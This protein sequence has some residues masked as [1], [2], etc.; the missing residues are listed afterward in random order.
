MIRALVI[1]LGL[2]AG[3]AV[4]QDLGGVARVD[5][6]SSHIRDDGRGIEIQLHLSQSVPFRVITLD[7]PRRLVLDFREIDWSGLTPDQI[8]QEG[9]VSGLRF[10]RYAATWSRM[11]ADLDGPYAVEQ[12]GMMV[13][14]ATGRSILRL[15]LRPSTPEAFSARAGVP[16]GDWTPRA[17][18]VPPPPRPGD[19]RLRVVLDPGHGGIDPGAQRDGLREADLMLTIAR[20]VKDTLLRTGD[21]EVAMT[22]EEDVFVPLETR[23][24]IA[25]AAKAHVFVSLHADAL[26]EGN[27]RGATVYT[28]SDTASDKAAQAMAERHSRDDLLAG[29]DLTLQDDQ[30]A[31]VLMDLARA[32]TAPRATR[33][34][35]T[36]VQTLK[37]GGLRVNKKP[38]R[39]AAISVLKSPDIPSVL[40][41]VGFLS[42]ADDRAA[43]QDP[44]VQADL[45]RAVAAALQNWA[46]DD[47]AR[48]DL[49]RK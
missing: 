38:L 9:H 43:L 33:L 44:A 22:R 35:E 15:L 30:I 32:E 18:A 26:L 7:D 11:V 20:Q 12:A 37:A 31:T 16:P 6:A 39:Q 13:M 36:L 27:A 45:A 2:L 3:P 8:W 28:L 24:S 4:A 49:L 17:L 41:E 25:K 14:P 46:L 47:A 21:F 29:V 23:I 5:P 48:A 10:G 40:L 42:D 19:G 34:A 1:L